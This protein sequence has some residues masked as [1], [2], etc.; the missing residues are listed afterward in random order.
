MKEDRSV[1]CF[2][3][4]FTS[5]S[6][7]QSIEDLVAKRSDRAQVNGLQ[8]LL[9][10]DYFRRRLDAVLLRFAPESNDH[11]AVV[12]FLKAWDNDNRSCN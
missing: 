3:S 8:H 2:A 12:R 10:L 9:D 6:W 4:A 5:H 1:A 7:G 11:Q